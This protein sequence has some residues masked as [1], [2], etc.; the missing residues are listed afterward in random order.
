MRSKKSGKDW[1]KKK[2]NHPSLLAL[3]PEAEKEKKTHACSPREPEDEIKTAQTAR[4]SLKRC[5][6]FLQSS[7]FHSFSF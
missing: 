2:W 4:L 7:F 1:E 5:I 3:E 6:L